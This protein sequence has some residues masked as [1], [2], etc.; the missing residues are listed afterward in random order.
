MTVRFLSL[1]LALTLVCVLPR[2]CLAAEH[3]APA[4]SVMVCDAGD[5][6]VNGYYRRDGT[7]VQP[8][9]RTALNRTRNDNYSTRGN[10]NPYTGERGT[11]PR[12]RE[13]RSSNAWNNGY[14]TYGSPRR[15]RHYKSGW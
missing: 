2:I 15:S 11:H 4:L 9:Y 7:Y 3:D 5:V 1:A 13:Y 12:D 6:Y 10:V 14:G 8:H